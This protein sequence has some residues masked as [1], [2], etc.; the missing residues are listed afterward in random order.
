M[1]L[2]L[3]LG[4]NPSSGLTREILVRHGLTVEV[5]HRFRREAAE[6]VPDLAASVHLPWTDPEFGRLNYAAAEPTFRELCLDRIRAAIEFSAKRF[7]SA[8]LAVMHGSPERWAPHAHSDG[9][10]GDY[11]AFIA[12]L[13]TLAD[14]AG[15][16]GMLLTLENNN[17]YWVNSEQRIT[18]QGSEPASDMCYFGCGPDAWRQAF[19]DASHENLRLC[20][21]TAHAC[22]WAHAIPDP[23]ERRAA[24]LSYLAEPSAIAH[25]HWNGHQAFEPE[26]R[27]DKHLSV[28]TG[29]IPRELHQGIARLPASHLLEHFHGEAALV[30]ELAFIHA[31]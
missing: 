19:H 31:L 9:R 28:G 30:E 5:S 27:V 10:V 15:T 17:R 14:V 22:T 25:V 21:D 6:D 23:A 4:Y 7:P 1:A 12:G 3:S 16:H 26:G 29:S 18:W 2:A 8:R 13:R 20:L 11:D 24:L